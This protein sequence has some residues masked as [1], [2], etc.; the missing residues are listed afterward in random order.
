MKAIIPGIKVQQ[1]IKSAFIFFV[2][3]SYLFLFT[4]SV[5][6][7]FSTEIKKLSIF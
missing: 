6:L 1:R 3:E 5:Y 7:V 2:A 4:F